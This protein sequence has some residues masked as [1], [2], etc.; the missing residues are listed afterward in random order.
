MKKLI[1]VYKQFIFYAEN[2][3]QVNIS[4][5]KRID[6]NTSKQEGKVKAKSNVFCKSMK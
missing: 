5:I 4:D 6:C 2:L 3:A 1:E